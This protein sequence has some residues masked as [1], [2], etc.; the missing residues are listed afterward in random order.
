[1]TSVLRLWIARGL[2]SN[3]DVPCRIA[4]GLACDRL[5]RARQ[6]RNGVIW[7]RSRDV[8]LLRYVL[9]LAFCCSL[10]AENF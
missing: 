6:L 10:S 4:V 2:W 9:V 1:M 5:Y 7:L 8:L 3:A